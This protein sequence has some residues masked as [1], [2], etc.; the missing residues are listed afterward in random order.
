MKH[1]SLLKV[2]NTQGQKEKIS[3]FKKFDSIPY[4][5][6]LLSLVFCDL[7]GMPHD[8]SKVPSLTFE[9]EFNLLSTYCREP[10][11]VIEKR[12]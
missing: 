9:S 4:F 6:G 11:T 10:F 5:T 1:Q 2:W 8:P 12:I 7:Y 3:V